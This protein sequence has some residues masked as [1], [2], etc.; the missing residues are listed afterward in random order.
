MCLSAPRQHHAFLPL[1]RAVAFFGQTANVAGAKQKSTAADSTFFLE[2]WGGLRTVERLDGRGAA[3]HW[4]LQSNFMK[5]LKEPGIDQMKI[6]PNSE[7]GKNES[8]VEELTA[9]FQI[10]HKVVSW[11]RGPETQTTGPWQVLALGST[12][13]YLFCSSHPIFRHA[14]LYDGCI[15]PCLIPNGTSCLKIWDAHESWL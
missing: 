1:Q 15:Q 4:V 3:K 9:W 14:D 11:A 13:S 2:S 12:S 8:V 10:G 7:K 5:K 6:K